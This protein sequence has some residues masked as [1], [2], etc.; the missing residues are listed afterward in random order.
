MAVK[1]CVVDIGRRLRWLYS[2]LMVLVI[3]SSVDRLMVV[4]NVNVDRLVVRVSVG[5]EDR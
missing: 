2:R 5:V 3:S 4:S 1:D